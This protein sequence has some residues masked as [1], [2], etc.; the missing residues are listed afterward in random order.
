MKTYDHSVL[1]DESK[2]TG[3]TTCIRHCPTEAISIGEDKKVVINQDACIGCGV[4]ETR[5]PYNLPIREMLK[6]AAVAMGK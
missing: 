2:C 5:C 6:K 4:C 1:L 3:C